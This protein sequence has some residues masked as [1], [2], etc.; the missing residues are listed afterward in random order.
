MIEDFA[1]EKST[2]IRLW[3]LPVLLVAVMAILAGRSFY[4][5]IMHGTRFL[6]AAEGNRMAAL[7]IPAPRGIIYDASGKALTENIAS[8]DVVLDPATLPIEENEQ[9]LIDRLPQLVSDTSPDHVREAVHKA[10]NTQRPTPLKKA[11]S[12]EE[13]LALEAAS[14]ELYGVRLVSTL[15]RQYGF[16]E[17]LAHVVGYTGAVTVEEL[18]KDDHLLSIDTTGKTGLEKFYEQTLRGKPG[19]EYLEVNVAGRP[20]KDLGRKEPV[21]GTDLHITLDAELQKEIMKIFRETTS[22]DGKPVS[23]AVI[24]LDPRDGAIRALVSFPSFDPNIFSQPSRSKET[25]RITQAPGNV[26]F[27]RA[28]DGLYPPG[29]TI[30]PFLGAAALQEGIITPDT[31]VLSTGGLHVGIWSFPD[32]KAGGHGMTDVKKAIAQSVNTFFYLVAGGDET[33]EGLGVD[34]LTNYLRKFGWGQ[35][36]EVDLPASGEGFLPSK[37]WKEKVKGEQWYIGDTYHLGIGQGDILVTPLQLAASTAALANGTHLVNP[38][39]NVEVKGSRD[40]LPVTSQV[41]E[42]VREGMRQTVTNGS[43]QRLST[44]P[45]ALAG[46]TGTAQVGGKETTHAWFTSFGPYEKPQLIITVLLEHGGEGDD[47]AVPFA[48]KIWKWWYENRF[49]AP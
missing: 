25:T 32:W 43:G 20:Q 11:I 35:T 48:E 30:K 46:K 13:V 38:H 15:V 40:S 26:L 49:Q 7:A 29:S 33:H 1:R 34:R 3:V 10:R 16:G 21:S 22:P 47:A 12:H 2:Q 19:A 4:L 44:F 45:I 9:Y 37:S 31:T 27:H 39:F 41:V 24:A 28:V 17:D 14:H 5:Q 8:T 36:E 23:G 18:E 6:S 42:T